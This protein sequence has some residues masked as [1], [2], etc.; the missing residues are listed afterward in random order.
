MTSESEV[1]QVAAQY[2]RVL[3]AVGRQR[4]QLTDSWEEASRQN[5]L[6][7]ETRTQLAAQVG[8]LEQ[9]NNVAVERE[10][11]MHELKHEVDDL[12]VGHGESP[13]YDT[14]SASE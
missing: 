5:E 4:R 14:V 8:S 11:R 13:R 1:G 10:L 2:N 6:L 7:H 3:D 9:F 12:L